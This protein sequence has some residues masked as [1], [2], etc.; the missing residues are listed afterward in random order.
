M[1]NT[2]I[3][4]TFDSEKLDAI[5]QFQ[6]VGSDNIETVLQEQL[7]KLY[8]KT[9]PIAVRKYIDGKI[10]PASAAKSN[11]NQHNNQIG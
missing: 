7:E 8:T 1:P 10:K 5:R 3:N 11:G 6:K 9:V 2:K 4:V